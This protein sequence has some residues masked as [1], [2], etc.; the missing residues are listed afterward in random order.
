[1]R[2]DLEKLDDSCVTRNIL[3]RTLASNLCEY[4][5][6]TTKTKLPLERSERKAVFLTARA[7]PGESNGSWMMKGAIEFLS[8]PLPEA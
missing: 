8:S 6:I 7:H 2:D 3:C 1:M 4:L 5:T